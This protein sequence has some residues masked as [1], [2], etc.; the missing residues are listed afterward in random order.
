MIAIEF[1]PLTVDVLAAAGFIFVVRVVGMSFS[2]VRMLLMM[3]GNKLGTAITGFIE[4]LL[5][6]V[7]IGGVVNN[8]SNIWNILG[9]SLGF[10]DLI[11][12]RSSRSHRLCGERVEVLVEQCATKAPL[13]TDLDAG[14]LAL[15]GQANQSPFGEFEIL[16]SLFGGQIRFHVNLLIA[17]GLRR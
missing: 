11:W 10:D 12:R 16:C 13:T 15:V 1:P 2:T 5:Y 3:R 17:G 9:Y 6:V 8:L 7:A 14:D 4:V